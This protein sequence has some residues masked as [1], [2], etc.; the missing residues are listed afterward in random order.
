MLHV[1]YLSNTYGYII[2]IILLRGTYKHDRKAKV[3]VVA[4]MT[5]SVT[6]GTFPKA[7]CTIEKGEEQMP[8]A[9][10]DRFPRW[11]CKRKKNLIE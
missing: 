8:K 3:Q 9:R 7:K 1:T 4:T 5:V 2:Y 10:A 11:H 6:G